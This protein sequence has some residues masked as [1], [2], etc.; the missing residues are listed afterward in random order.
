MENNGFIGELPAEVLD[1]NPELT[2]RTAILVRMEVSISSTVVIAALNDPPRC[3]DIK[4]TVWYVRVLHLS[5]F[6][7]SRWNRAYSALHVHD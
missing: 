6:A 3:R 1:P 2:P 7:F 4:N 5:G